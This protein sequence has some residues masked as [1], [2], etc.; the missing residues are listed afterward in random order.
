M[1]DCWPPPPEGGIF[2]GLGELLKLIVGQ[3]GPI[4]KI[5]IG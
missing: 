2:G 3:K 4:H 5:W 1:W